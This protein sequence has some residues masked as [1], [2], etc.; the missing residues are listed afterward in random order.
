MEEDYDWGIILKVSIP[1]SL[2]VGYSFYTNISNF[3][4]WLI[5]FFGL[6]TAAGIVNM[7]S[8]KKANVFTAAAIVFLAALAVRFMRN[9][10]F[11]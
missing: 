4:K 11:M 6:I 10:G 5:L 7:K 9:S 2:V 1:I 8:K 3:W